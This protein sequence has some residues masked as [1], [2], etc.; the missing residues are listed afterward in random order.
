M[1]ASCTRDG[2]RGGGRSEYAICTPDFD[3]Y[4][5]DLPGHGEIKSAR[6]FLMGVIPPGITPADVYWFRALTGPEAAALRAKGIDVANQE[7]RDAPLVLAHRGTRTRNQRRW[8]N[9]VRMKMTQ[10]R[11]VTI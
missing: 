5:E 4:V 2:H 9:A 6:P 11:R 10:P 3:V 1:R 7:R 8:W